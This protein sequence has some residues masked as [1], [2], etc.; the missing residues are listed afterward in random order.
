M[1]RQRIHHTRETYEV[2]E[3]FPQRLEAFRQAAGLSR[4]E[5]PRQLR[6][7]ARI[8]KRWKNET[9]PDSANLLALFILAAGLGLLHLLLLEA[10]EP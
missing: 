10:K 5:L 1:P 7:N 3:D 2:P 8:L 9:R 6:T 4:R